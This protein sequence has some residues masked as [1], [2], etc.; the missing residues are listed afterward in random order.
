MRH[1]NSRKN[2]E[3]AV[4]PRHN[5]EP[6]TEHFHALAHADETQ[7]EVTMAGLHSA[8]VICQ[9][10]YDFIARMVCA[11]LEADLERPVRP[12]ARHVAGE[13]PPLDLELHLAPDLHLDL[14]EGLGEPGADAS[15][16]DP[17]VPDLLGR[18]AFGATEEGGEFPA[19]EDEEGEAERGEEEEGERP[20]QMSTS[21]RS[22]TSR[23]PTGAP[24]RSTTGI[25]S[26]R[27]SAGCTP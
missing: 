19:E 7:S 3:A 22:W 6:A 4:W 12:G 20:L 17:R 8:A 14:P 15:D 27:S 1:W 25:W 9:A 24:L 13:G 16:R 26:M 23:R 11:A 18:R 2:A 5:L 21:R 10:Q